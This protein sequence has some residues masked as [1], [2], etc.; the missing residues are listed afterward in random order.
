MLNGYRMGLSPMA[1]A[2]LMTPWCVQKM[3]TTIGG[4]VVNMISS[5]AP[6]RSAPEQREQQRYNAQKER[7]T[8]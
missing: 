3:P 1:R 7:Y 4:T 8:R 6:I 5:A 2:A